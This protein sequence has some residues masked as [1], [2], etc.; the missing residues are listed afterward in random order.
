MTLSSRQR[1]KISCQEQRLISSLFIA[2]FVHLLLAFLFRDIINFQVPSGNK[3]GSSLNIKLSFFSDKIET[4]P[5][6]TIATEPSV[7][8]VHQKDTEAIS[9]AA[10]ESTAEPLPDVI[11]GK[12]ATPE[13]SI[14][15]NQNSL[16]E[17]IDDYTT[18]SFDE[19]SESYTNFQRSFNSPEIGASGRANTGIY[20]DSQNLST[21][22]RENGEAHVKTKLFGKNVCYKFNAGANAGYD[23]F[24]V[25]EVAFPYRCPNKEN[26]FRLS[27]R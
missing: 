24:E 8:P 22:V 15:L 27:E 26:S 10:R 17:W 5:V 13:S 16:R 20:S 12:S 3:S 19:D 7:E 9:P 25:V 14:L 23:D 18:D 4:T 21:Y 11:T 2:I 6:K 1:A